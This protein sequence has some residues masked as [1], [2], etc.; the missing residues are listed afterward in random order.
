MTSWMWILLLFHWTHLFKKLSSPCIVCILHV[1]LRCLP[2][3]RAPSQAR[4]P[5]VVCWQW[6]GWTVKAA[7]GRGWG[8]C[9]QSFTLGWPG[10]AMCWETWFRIFQSFLLDWSC[11]QNTFLIYSLEDG[12]SGSQ[13]GQ[14]MRG[15]CQHLAFQSVHGLV[16]GE[17]PGPH[18]CLD[19]PRSQLLVYS[20]QIINL[21]M[22]TRAEKG[23]EKGPR[24]REPTR[25]SDWEVAFHLFFP[26]PTVFTTA[27]GP[28]LSQL[29]NLRS[30][31]CSFPGTFVLSCLRHT[32]STTMAFWLPKWCNAFYSFCSHSLSLKITLC[33][34]TEVLAAF[35]QSIIF[36]KASNLSPC[37]LF[38]DNQFSTQ[39]P[40]WSLYRHKLNDS[41]SLLEVL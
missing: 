12:V 39:Q 32:Q 41:T 19:G 20:H 6:R 3:C 18:L 2:R 14:G 13:V 27:P 10:Q 7:L 29:L 28:W 4:W 24:G 36:E 11:P 38:S 1:A 37:C 8:L 25:G 30:H 5:L 23:P 22:S 17:V 34:F 33:G 21:Q 16:T 35:I 26:I 31:H 40:D 15:G 9:T